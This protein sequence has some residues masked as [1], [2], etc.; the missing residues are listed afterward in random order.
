[1]SPLLST[2]AGAS[3]FGA[4][5]TSAGLPKTTTVDLFALGGGGNGGQTSNVNNYSSGSTGGASSLTARSVVPGTTYTVTVGAAGNPSEVAHNG[6]TVFGSAGSTYTG[7]GTYAS[8][9]VWSVCDF[10]GDC[11]WTRVSGT[12]GQLDSNLYYWGGAGIYVAYSY[13]YAALYT[14]SLNQSNNNST[15]FTGN[16]VGGD[17]RVAATTFQNVYGSNW[18]GTQGSQN[19]SP[20][21][22]NS[23]STPAANNGAGG[24]AGVLGS[25]V[26]GG[27][28]KVQLKYP[29]T[30]AELS[31]TTGTVSYTTS[32]GNHIY[33][34]TS[35][36]SYTI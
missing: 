25:N 26:S 15:D 2:F 22:F 28:G 16:T 12:R 35:S 32:G 20:L 18:Y 9:T 14:A 29:T 8:T 19:I 21:D 17:G 23:Y 36:G 34:W 27:S 31:A 7:Q 1:M 33:T 5:H 13:Y 3:A 11:G 24:W 30:F 4:W 6:G 10:E